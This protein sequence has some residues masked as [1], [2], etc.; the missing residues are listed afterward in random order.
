MLIS[1][2]V[3]V[4]WNSN[5]KRRFE[6]LGYTYTSVGDEFLVNVQDLSKG[7]KVCVRVR[8]DYC[9]R[10]FSKPY[11]GYIRAHSIVDTDCC[12]DKS[13][14]TQKAQE[15]IYAKYNVDNIAHCADIVEKRRLTNLERYGVENPFASESVKAKIRATNIERLGVPYPC[16]STVVLEKTKQTCLEK[17]G[18]PCFLN[19]DFAGEK[20]KGENN[21]KWRGGIVRG[22]RNG[23]HA[24]DYKNWRRMVYV[25]DEYTCQ[26]CGAKSG[27]NKRLKLNAHHVYNWAS[28]PEYRLEVSNGITLC[29]ECHLLFHSIYGKQRNTPEQLQAFLTHAEKIC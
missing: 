13:C 27:K 25:R 24:Q 3:P 1:K 20:N 29:E 18:V 2:E 10:E 22:E 21:P 12:M 7:S 5:N 4:R 16:M 14:T 17:Y 6:E 11:D 19:L 23:Y 8:C 26:M 28:Y 15:V 9:G